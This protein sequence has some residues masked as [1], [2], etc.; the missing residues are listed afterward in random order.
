[1]I[2]TVDDEYV[3]VDECVRKKDLCFWCGQRRALVR[4]HYPLSRKYG[5]EIVNICLDCH[6][7]YHHGMIVFATDCNSGEEIDKRMHEELI[8]AFPLVKGNV[9]GVKVITINPPWKAKA[10]HDGVPKT[11]RMPTWKEAMGLAN[12]KKIVS[13]SEISEVNETSSM[14]EI[15]QHNLEAYAWLL[16]KGYTAIP[17]LAWHDPDLNPLDKLVLLEIMSFSH[18]HGG[19]KLFP[20]ENRLANEV[21]L[22]LKTVQRA[23]RALLKQG[24]LSKQVV[25]QEGKLSTSI[26]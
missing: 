18:R 24:W 7:K 20:R 19:G 14:S 13:V 22:G 15:G 6:D 25:S 10:Y 21:G 11:W 9:E 4:H 26:L 8:A 3:I 16:Q 23:K 12:G 17:G 1:M 5:K 2:R